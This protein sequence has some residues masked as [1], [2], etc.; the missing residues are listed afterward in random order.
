MGKAIHGGRQGVYMKSVVPAP[1]CYEPKN[2]VL[3]KVVKVFWNMFS[4]SFGQNAPQ[5]SRLTELSQILDVFQ[6]MTIRSE[7]KEKKERN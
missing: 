5:A 1:M 3:K 7:K 6:G 4:F 2:S